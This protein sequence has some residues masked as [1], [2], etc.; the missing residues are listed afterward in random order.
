M[1]SCVTVLFFFFKKKFKCLPKFYASPL[2]RVYLH[3]GGAQCI[4]CILYLLE[5]KDYLFTYLQLRFLL[6]Q[7]STQFWASSLAGTRSGESK[8]RQGTQDIGGA[9]SGNN[10]PVCPSQPTVHLPGQLTSSGEPAKPLKCGQSCSP[11]VTSAW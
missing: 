4:Q 2:E 10:H 7:E 3:D 6:P 5:V 1:F 11:I 8:A 9:F